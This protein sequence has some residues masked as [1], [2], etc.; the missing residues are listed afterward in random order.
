MIALI[1]FDEVDHNVKIVINDNNIMHDQ[2]KSKTAIFWFALHKAEVVVDHSGNEPEN[3][4]YRV[5]WK[6]YNNED[7]DN[8]E[9]I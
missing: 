1:Y 4:E 8:W 2:C 9:L 6:C 3:R 7:K 5:R